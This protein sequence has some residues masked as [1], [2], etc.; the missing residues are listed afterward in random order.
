MYTCNYSF[1]IIKESPVCPSVNICLVNTTP[2]YEP[3]LMKLHT[4]AV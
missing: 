2:P 1:F 3:I 4:V